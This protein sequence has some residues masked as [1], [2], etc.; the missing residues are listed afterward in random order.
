MAA[1]HAWD[2]QLIGPDRGCYFWGTSI[3]NVTPSF[4]GIIH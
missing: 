3:L 2:T 1:S 4:S